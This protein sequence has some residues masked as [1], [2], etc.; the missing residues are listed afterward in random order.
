MDASN[1]AIGKRVIAPL[2]VVFAFTS[3]A[4]V[5][6]AETVL[7]APAAKR[8]DLKLPVQTMEVGPARR[9][10]QD[11]ANEAEDA[12]GNEDQA[13]A[14]LLAAILLIPPPIDLVTDIP[15]SQP[16]A[17]HTVVA[18]GPDLNVPSIPGGTNTQILHTEGAPE[19]TSLLLG[20]LGAGLVATATWYRRRRACLATPVDADSEELAGATA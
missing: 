11:A 12:T 17:T 19:P 13:R 18:K 10:A 9:L 2:A 15:V 6:R 1:T 16:E 4:T 3:M 7:Q 20:A 5:G 8:A 14:A